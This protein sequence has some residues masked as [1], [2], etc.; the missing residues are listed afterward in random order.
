MPCLVISCV[1]KCNCSTSLKAGLARHSCIIGGHCH[2]YHFCCNKTCLLLKQKYACHEAYFCRDKHMF[3]ATKHVFW[4][5]KSMLVMTKLLL[6]MTNTFCQDKSCSKH[7]FVM[8]KDVFCHDKQNTQQTYM[9]LSR[10]K[11][12]L[13]QLLPMILLMHSFSSG[14]TLVLLV[15]LLALCMY[16]IWQ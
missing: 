3:V 9:C 5:D 7:T 8:T 1:T 13:W 10:Q 16:V 2:K 11:L 6:H 12:Y 14:Q 15:L 4:R